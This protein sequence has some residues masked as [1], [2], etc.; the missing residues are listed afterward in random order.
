YTDEADEIR[1]AGGYLVR[2][3]RPG[4][5]STDT[6][7]SEVELDAYPT[8]RVIVND[9]TLDAIQPEARLIA[10]DSVLR[11]YKSLASLVRSA[12]TGRGF[13]LPRDRRASDVSRL[14]VCPYENR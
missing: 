5:A 3:L 13:C 2:V 4:Q 7:S 9:G 6:H 10:R 8:N 1:R 11:R 14:L 12:S